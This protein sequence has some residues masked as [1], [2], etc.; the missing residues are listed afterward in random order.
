VRFASGAAFIRL[1]GFVIEGAKG[2]SSTNVYF[3]GNTHDVEVSASEIRFS[4][5][6]GLFAERTTRNI[7]IVQ[8]RI[9][10]NGWGHESGQHQSH[11]IYIEGRDHLLANNV[12]YDH[13]HGFGVQV[14]PEN[15]GTIV[16][17]NTIVNSG[18]SAIVVGG[19]RGVGEITIRNNIL[20]FSSKYG[21]Q[22]D[23]SCPTS[24]VWVDTNLIYGNRSGAVQSGCSSVTTSGGNVFADPRF[25]DRGRHNFQLRKGSPAVDRARADYA[26]RTDLW[27]R[28]RP[29]GTGYDVG[30]LERK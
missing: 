28:Q 17:N 15:R 30:A 5:D 22:T 27:G 13:P 25:V 29:R 26:P 14:Y 19:P 23:S 16:V 21:V 7:H 12:V 11:G 18:H 9:H 20:A 2:R 24:R 4:Q 1:R 3:E 10:D 8:N 6:Q